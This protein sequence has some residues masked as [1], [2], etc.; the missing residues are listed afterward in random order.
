[1]RRVKGV[2]QEDGAPRK[3]RLLPGLSRGEEG[4]S[5]GD[6]GESL[7]GEGGDVL[8]EL[9]GYGVEVGGRSKTSP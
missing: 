3:A 7:R 1:M 2:N 5:R 8:K 9:R 6:G 4:V